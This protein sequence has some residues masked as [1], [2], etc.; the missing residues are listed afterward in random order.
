MRIFHITFIQ[1][2]LTFF[3]PTV[4]K[5]GLILLQISIKLQTIAESSLHCDLVVAPRL[6]MGSFGQ[7]SRGMKMRL[8]ALLLLYNSNLFTLFSNLDKNVATIKMVIRNASSSV[9]EV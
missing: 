6:R 5:R 2:S 4:M 3:G 7:S 1:L 8:F 9:L